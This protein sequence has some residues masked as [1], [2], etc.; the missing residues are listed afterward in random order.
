MEGTSSKVSTI[1]ATLAGGAVMVVGASQADAMIISGEIQTAGS[2]QVVDNPVPP[3]ETYPFDLNND[4]VTD[5]TV[6]SKYSKSKPGAPDDTTKF[7]SYKGDVLLAAPDNAISGTL[8]SGEE[9][10]P[11]LAYNMGAGVTA[12]YDNG[13][14]SAYFGLRFGATAPY[15][16]GWIQLRE[17]TQPGAWDLLAYGIETTPDT[18]IAAGAVPEP[19][20]LGALA[21]GAAAIMFRRRSKHA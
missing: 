14:P 19:T 1:A 2:E 8:T 5:L 21:I 17:G 10:G 11:S 3:N 16:Y 15:N 20:S 18:P 4:T 7:Y 13:N 9:V 6:S 12:E